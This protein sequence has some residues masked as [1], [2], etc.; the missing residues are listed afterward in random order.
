MS[1]R[2]FDALI[3]RSHRFA[4][5]VLSMAQCQLYTYEMREL[6][7]NGNVYDRYEV[8]MPRRPEII[9]NVPMKTVA[10]YL[11]MSPQYL[12]TLRKEWLNRGAGKRKG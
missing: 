4:Q 10:A 1:A 2:D 7:L 9:R 3:E 6:N 5:W 11:G 8:L 12:S